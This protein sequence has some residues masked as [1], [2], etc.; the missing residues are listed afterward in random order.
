[1]GTAAESHDQAL[2][3]RLMA[4]LGDGDPKLRGARMFGCPAAFVGRRLA[5][6]VFGGAV[7][8]KLPPAE[9][10]RLLADGAAVAFRP[11]G[12]PPMKEWVEL[13][14]HDPDGIEAILP[15]LR[16]ASRYAA[17]RR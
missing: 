13:R 14:A 12:R 3:D 7:G 15:V 1:M 16:L 17:G 9:A 4:R 10:A 5:F 11:F 8:A 2:F 6:C